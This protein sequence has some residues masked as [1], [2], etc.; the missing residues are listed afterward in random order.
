MAEEAV[1]TAVDGVLG[2]VDNDI[3]SLPLRIVIAFLQELR[4]VRHGII[5]VGHEHGA[6]SGG[7]A[8]MTGQADLHPVGAAVGITQISD[9]TADIAAG[10]LTEDD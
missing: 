3:G 8:G 2:P 9:R 6:L 7:I 4:A 5:A 1:K 10:A